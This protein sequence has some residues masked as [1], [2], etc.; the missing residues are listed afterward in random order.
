MATS[1]FQFA[2]CQSIAHRE[3]CQI[4]PRQTICT[5]WGKGS[6]KTSIS[7][8]QVCT[9]DAVKHLSSDR[10]H[11]GISLYNVDTTTMK[12]VSMHWTTVHFFDGEGHLGR[13][14]LPYFCISLKLP[15]ETCVSHPPTLNPRKVGLWSACSTRNSAT[16]KISFVA[17]W[18]PPC[19]V[20]GPKVVSRLLKEQELREV[21]KIL[22]RPPV[23][24]DN[25]HANDYDQTRLFL[26][27]Y[28]GRP[29][30]L[31][32]CLRGVIQQSVNSTFPSHSNS[33]TFKQHSRERGDFFRC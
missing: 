9:N 12:G 28:D 10:L 31:V 1:L 33:T 24:W 15:T 7:C 20:S 16:E 17:L 13:K 27:P 21:S 18:T 23:I 3:Q 6:T 25:L 26:G 29:P 8:G 32:N 5:L 2:F 14:K 11:F 19:V 30:E 4:S 22:Q